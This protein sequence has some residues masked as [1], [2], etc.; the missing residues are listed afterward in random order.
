MP[1]TCIIVFTVSAGVM[2]ILQ[3]AAM[4]DA[5]MVTTA[6]GH[7][8][9]NNSLLNSLLKMSPKRDNGIITSAGARPL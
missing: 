8:S 3:D 9:D 4:D 6:A 7:E 5:N 1:W 2:S